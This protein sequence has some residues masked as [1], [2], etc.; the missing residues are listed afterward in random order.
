M[1][2]FSL[3]SLLACGP[4]AGPAPA[5]DLLPADLGQ[6]VVVEDAARGV[7]VSVQLD[8]WDD[9][10]RADMV[11][12]LQAMGVRTLRHDL[13]WDYVQ[14]ARDTWD[15]SKED[16]W[17]D[18]AVGGGFDVLAMVAYGNPWATSVEGADAFYPPD[19]PADFAAFAAAAAE[20]YGDRV[21]RWEVWNEP[22]AGYR[23][24]KVGDPPAIGGD[25]AGYAALFV[26][27]ADAIHGVDPS[28]EVQIGGTFFHEQAIPGGPRFVA[29]AAAAEP[30]FLEV[31]D[32]V[33][34]HPYTLYPPRV[35]PEEGEGD[36]TPLWDMDA[37]MAAATGGLPRAITEAG[38]PSYDGVDEDEQAAWTVRELLLAQ[39]LGTRDVCVY[40]L[41]DGTD[42]DNAEHA[43]G[44][45]TDGVGAI[46]PA[47]EALAE[48]AAAIAG[49]DA[50]GRAEAALGLP[51]G[52]LAVRYLT[53]EEAITAV[54]TVDGEVSATVPASAEGCSGEGT[55]VVAG[56]RPTW[57][58]EALCR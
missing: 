35:P 50:H 23:F 46:K 49:A 48:A 7:C 51:E 41:E 20:R 3:L 29:E 26:A 24:W 6:P 15:W 10:H 38:W 27:A 5:A 40:T 54:W 9:A 57:V 11:A 4:S 47:G 25:P 34:W 37:E 52:V 31:A 14:Y 36:E 33:A 19:D 13:R 43:F 58:R 45:W 28:F 17:V 1:T 42:P 8:R 12:A 44:L 22:N 39:A 32:A 16:A 2:T 30:R 56:E 55:T 53:P 21:S 18:A